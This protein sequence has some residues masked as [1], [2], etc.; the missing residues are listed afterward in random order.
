[1]LVLGSIRLDLQALDLLGVRLHRLVDRQQDACHLD[2]QRSALGG[3]LALLEPSLETISG[4]VVRG[5]DLENLAI[6]LDGLLGL[7]E[8]V[9]HDHAEAQ[10][11]LGAGGRIGILVGGDG[12]LALEDSAEVF[13][14]LQV[15]V[16]PV[17]SSEHL[18]V[19]DAG[20]EHRVV[21]LD[22]LVVMTELFVDRADP[23][24]GR[25]PLLFVVGERELG[26]EDRE[27]ILF[28]AERQV[29][30]LQG[31]ERGGLLGVD[32]DDGLVHRQRGVEVGHVLLVDLRQLEP[33]G[34]AVGGFA[35]LLDRELQR[36]RERLPLVGGLGEALEML[37]RVGGGVILF[38][39]L[40]IEGKRLLG[41]VRDAF[42]EVG[43][44][45][46]QRLPSLWVLF[47]V[48][49]D[50]KRA[51]Q[52]SLVARVLVQFDQLLG[53]GEV[54]TIGQ[55]L[56]EGSNRTLGLLDLVAVERRDLE[57]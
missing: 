27:Q 14:P 35:E 43:E 2:A 12:E 16:D 31:R 56:L 50:L 52:V 6:Q 25:P 51:R 54:V 40:L 36:L 13:P 9:L 30:T 4:R 37:T 21:G 19:L 34:Q 47:V 22:R 45:T 57:L 33:Q 7:V 46:Q 55:R 28:A 41:L 29:Q 38:E 1:M 32:L 24:L 8:A 39:G 42:G 49:L 53:D 48:E 15:A 3:L 17:E 20:V 26:V 18:G 10:Q 11:V 23:S 5:I 44:P